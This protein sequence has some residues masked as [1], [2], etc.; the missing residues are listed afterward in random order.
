M[1]KICLKK[2]IS[3]GLVL[4]FSATTFALP[5]MAA[6][7]PR[8]HTRQHVSRPGPNPDQIQ[9]NATRPSSRPSGSR[10]HNG[11][12]GNRTHRQS[13]G[14]TV[15]NPNRP[16]GVHRPNPGSTVRNPNRP[17]GVNRPNPGSTIRNPGSPNPGATIRNPGAE[18]RRPQ[19]PDINRPGA[20]RPRPNTPG[21]NRPGPQRPGLNHP[22]PQRPGPNHPGPNRPG[23][24]RPAPGPHHFGPNRPYRPNHY[25][26]YPYW[27]RSGIVFH[28]GYPRA[29]FWWGCRRGISFGDY[30]VI[31]MIVTA[32]RQATMDDIYN[33]HLNGESYESICNHYDVDWY[34]INSNA[35]VR[36][37]EMNL[38]ATNRGLS[39]W[40][41]NDILTY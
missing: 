15:R 11:G 27:R 13:S 2:V 38:Y 22:G 14:S 23:P 40:A 12:N 31:T 8:T 21:V 28:F 33:R 4:C 9:Q 20:N 37:N 10:Q 16:A 1:N 39:F 26:P 18:N 29:H 3:L 24:N 30:L 7:G 5:V 34:T 19:R 17:A 6:P 32:A 36:F 25:R 41:W 35:R